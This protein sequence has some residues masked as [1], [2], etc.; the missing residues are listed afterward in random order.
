M[1]ASARRHGTAMLFHG[2]RTAN[3]EIY[4]MDRCR[5]FADATLPSLRG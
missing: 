5:R 3:G 4:D 1:T 2:R